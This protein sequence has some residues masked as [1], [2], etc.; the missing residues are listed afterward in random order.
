M[1]HYLFIDGAYLRCV[2]SNISERFFG[3]ELVPLDFRKLQRQT[4]AHKVFYYGCDLATQEDLLNELRMVPGMH[5]YEGVLSG[6]GGKRRQKMVDTMMAIDMLRHSYR[7]NAS[8]MTLL[9]GDLDFKPLVDALVEAGTYVVI[10]YEKASASQGLIDAADERQ[11]L[12]VKTLYELSKPWFWE[13]HRDTLP[14]DYDYSSRS[15]QLDGFVV[16]KKGKL[17]DGSGVQLYQKEE[18][19]GIALFDPYGRSPTWRCIIDKQARCELLEKYIEN[20]YGAFEWEQ[21]P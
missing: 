11:H 20:V 4:V 15:A 9:A 2:V 19:L 17:W 16:A 14:T 5:F 8:R 12:H 13:R 1:S 18:E 3:G 10:W 7:K 21:Q 6:K